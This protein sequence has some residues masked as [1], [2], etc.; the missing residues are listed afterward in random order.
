MPLGDSGF[1]NSLYSSVQ[2][3]SELLHSAGQVDPPTPSPTFVKVCAALGSFNLL[4][5]L[6]A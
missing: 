4:L 1:Q 3:S 5:F 2:D 6:L